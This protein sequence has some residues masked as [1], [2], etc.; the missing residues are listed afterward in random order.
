MKKAKIL[1]GIL[2]ASLLLLSQVS[3]V[4]ARPTLKHVKVI[5]GT[6]VAITL[7]TTPSSG[8]HT[9]FVTIRDQHGVERTFRISEETAYQDLHLLDY[10]D[11]GNPFIVDALPGTIELDPATAIPD[12]EEFHH[13]VAM[14]LATFFRDVDGVDYNTIMDA[15]TSGFGFGAIAQ[16]LWMIQKLDGTADDFLLLL[17]AKQDGDFSDFPLADGTIP[18][19]WGQLRKAI[20]E[21][22]GTVVSQKDKDTAYKNPQDNPDKGNNK[23]KDKDKSNN[24]NAGGNGNSNGHGNKP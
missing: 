14:A 19:T 4:F 24:G 7:E 23:D 22:L 21:N 5:S 17:Q 12:E 3:A 8:I 2:L 1:V 15:H 6:I 16:A 13:P 10:D 20:S 18:T 11:D 9:V